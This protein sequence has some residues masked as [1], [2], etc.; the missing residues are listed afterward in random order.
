[1]PNKRMGDV[2]MKVGVMGLISLTAYGAF[3]LSTG[4]Y[5]LRAINK[6]YDEE[7]KKKT[8]TKDETRN[9]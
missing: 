1:M 5:R 9:Q 4:L 2:A 3:G 6:A 7:L 8:T